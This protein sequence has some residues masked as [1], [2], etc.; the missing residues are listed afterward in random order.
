MSIFGG[1]CLT[2]LIL[3]LIGLSMYSYYL[4]VRSIKNFRNHIL[5]ELHEIAR[6]IK[7]K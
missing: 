5:E 4:E 2:L 6:S 1:V 3:S 7:S